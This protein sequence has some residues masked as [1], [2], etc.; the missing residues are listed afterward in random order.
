MQTLMLNVWIS[1]RPYHLSFHLNQSKVGWSL[2]AEDHFSLLRSHLLVLEAVSFAG[3]G[4][5]YKGEQSVV[6]SDT[7]PI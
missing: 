2:P 4:N 6:K 1:T 7:P 3:I 5:I